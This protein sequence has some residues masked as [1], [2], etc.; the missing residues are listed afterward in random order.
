MRIDKVDLFYLA[1]PRVTRAAD[2]T[3][4][5]V[6]V[7]LRDASG[8]E[9]W[10]EC[11]ASPL[12]TIAAYAC[13]PSHGNIVGLRE[14]LVG[15]RLETPADVPRIGERVLREALD[16]EHAHHALSGADI[17]LW[18]LL[19]KRLREPAWRLLETVEPGPAGSGLAAP[20][21]KL[22]YASVLFEETP[23]ATRERARALR[24]EGFEA[25]KLGWGPMGRH[26]EAFDVALVEE[27]RAGLG[28]G[29]RL[30]V[31]AGCAWGEDDEIAWRR[32]RAFAPFEIGWLEEPFLPD[33]IAAYGRLRRR[34]PAVPIAAGEGS[35]RLRFAEDLLENGG[36]DYIQIDAG[37]IGG[38]TA[39]FRV[40]RLAERRGATYVNH[41]FKSHLSLAA[42]IHVFATAERFELL[43]YPAGGSEL[44][45]ALV[46][47]PLLRGRDGLVRA[48]DAPGL[49][50]EVDLE[51]VRRFVKPV[52][53]EVAGRVVEETPRV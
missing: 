21:P 26:G 29:A 49:G 10:G 7:R 43:E 25:V 45:R 13:P 52:R 19:G 17:A 36:V 53:I 8:L 33:A 15:E 42:A 40:R 2:G 41:T 23:M 31:D 27:A 37:R 32:A 20:R 28:P 11:D 5:S 35:N 4:D 51:A 44:S 48:P 3:Q 50:V 38:M 46:R 47:D 14:V 34:G 22:P 1:M 24:A 6:L 30:L 16:I 9:G 39:A 18:D 12:V